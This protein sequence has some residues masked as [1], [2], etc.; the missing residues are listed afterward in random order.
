MS[1]LGSLPHQIPF[2]AASAVQRRDVS[3][4]EGTFLWT[5]NDTMPPELMLVEAMAQF[6]GGL[7][8]DPTRHGFVSGIDDCRIHRAIEPGDL[9]T[10][11]VTL[12]GDFAGIF[13]FRGTAAANGVEVARARFYLA[14]Q[15][16][17]GLG[18]RAA[19]KP[20]DPEA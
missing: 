2:R 20:S 15:G 9:L 8:F 11:Q 7:V 5:A 19:E 4:I 13:R 3:S 16:A 6:G 1:W 17:S 14:D 10:V 18:P 12:D